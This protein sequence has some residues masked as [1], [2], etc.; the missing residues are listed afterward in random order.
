MSFSATQWGMYYGSEPRY[1]GG[2]WFGVALGFGWGA[3]SARVAYY[4]FRESRKIERVRLV[5]KRTSHLLPPE[6]SLVR[7][8]SL[9]PPQQ[10]NELLRA[11]HYGKDTPAEQLLRAGE[12]SGKDV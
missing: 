9:S 10:Q 11:T 4:A 3:W 6:D 1:S 2:W 5:T 12:A 7:A 8:S